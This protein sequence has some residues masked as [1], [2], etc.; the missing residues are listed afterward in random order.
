MICISYINWN[1]HTG[2]CVCLDLYKLYGISVVVTVL[3]RL[4]ADTNGF[5]D[6]RRLGLL[7]HDCMQVPRQLGEVASFGGSNI[8]PSVRSCFEMVRTFYVCYDPWNPLWSLE[9]TLS[10]LTLIVTCLEQDWSMWQLFTDE[11]KWFFLYAF[12]DILMVLLP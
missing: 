6:K 11:K 3:F 4:I 7:L 2:K 5:S 12:H 8:E 1:L 10:I 9:D